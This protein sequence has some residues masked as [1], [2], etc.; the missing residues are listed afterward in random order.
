[1]ASHC[2]VPSCFALAERGRICVRCRLACRRGGLVLC[3]KVE[4]SFVLS[5]NSITFTFEFRRHW[6]GV[7]KDFTE[8]SVIEILIYKHIL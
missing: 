6:G 3:N 5:G 4:F 1:M 7:W 2:V 8:K